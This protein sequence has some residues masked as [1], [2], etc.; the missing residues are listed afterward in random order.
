MAALAT[1]DLKQSSARACRKVRS[2]CS[3]CPLKPISS[4]MDLWWDCASQCEDCHFTLDVVSNCVFG[5]V[6]SKSFN[7]GDRIRR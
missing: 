2:F 4:P 6:T 7:V 3:T 5:V 1:S